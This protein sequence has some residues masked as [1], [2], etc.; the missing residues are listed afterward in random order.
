MDARNTYHF[1]ASGQQ[2]L[3]STRRATSGPAPN[4]FS[5]GNL[6]LD[7][8]HNFFLECGARANKIRVYE[9]VDDPTARACVGFLLVR[10]GV[11][12]V[13]YAKALEKLTGVDVGKLL[14]IPDISNKR[15]PEAA[16]HEAQGLHRIL[17]RFSPD[18]YPRAGEIWNGPHPE[19]GSDLEVQEGAPGGIRPAR[20]GRRAAAD[21]ARR[22]RHRP[23]DVSRR[24]QQAVSRAGTEAETERNG[25]DRESAHAAREG[26]PCQEVT[27]SH[28]RC[29]L[30]LWGSNAELISCTLRCVAAAD[31]E[32]GMCTQRRVKRRWGRA[33][34]YDGLGRFRLDRSE[35][36]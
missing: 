9:M 11:H 18:D 12:I 17:Y 21:G 33:A 27:R 36:D 2:A 14:P 19:D 28:S 26:L 30:L 7:L 3:P 25:R 31:C 24:R 4:V 35:S 6:K 10:G 34:G 23:R 8:L 20:P 22:T 1:L 32:R 29:F 13:A 16:E 15:F 5:S